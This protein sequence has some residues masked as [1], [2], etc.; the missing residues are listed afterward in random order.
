MAFDRVGGAIT[1]IQNQVD[2]LFNNSASRSFGTLDPTSS[3]ASDPRFSGLNTLPPAAVIPPPTITVPFVPFV[4]NGVGFGDGN[5]ELNYT[6]DKNFKIPYSHMFNFGIQRELPGNMIIDVS[7]VGRMGRSLFVQTDT[8]QVLNF[9]DNASGQFLFDALNAMQATIQAN[10]AAG[11]PPTQGLVAQPWFENQVFAGGTNLVAG[12]LTEL[13]RT[14]GT[15]DIINVLHAN[16]LLDKNVSMSSQFAAN[17]YITNQGFSNYHGA[18]VSLQKRFSR[19]FEFDVNYTFSHALDNNSSQTNTVTGGQICDFT[20]LDLCYS[21]ADFDIRHLFNAN[22][23]WD[24]PFGRSRQ[25]GSGMPGW[26]DAVIGGWTISGIASARSGFPLNPAGGG[27]SVRY[28]V[29]TPPI[30]VGDT[31]AFAP[32]IREEGGGIQY[33][34][35]PVAAN[36]ALRYPHHGEIGTRNI[37]RSPYFWGLDLGLAKKFKMPWSENHTLTF[38]ADM[39]NATNTNQFSVPNLTINSTTFGRITGSLSSPREIQFAVR[40]DF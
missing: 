10:L 16:G 4:E 22:F 3:L 28:F 35:D 13:V 38:R 7:Y 37:F 9:R 17:L 21:H 34:A 25:F 33:F 23:I 19:G 15:S 31:S 26:A 2:Y 11:N 27:F 30:L 36:A 32:N 40:Y 1:F 39:F 12:A 29:S 20:N 14:G 18:L 6:I 5:G 24:L 8:S